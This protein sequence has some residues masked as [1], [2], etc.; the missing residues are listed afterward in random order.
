[1][2]FLYNHLFLRLEL[3]FHHHHNITKS[4]AKMLS[5]HL[6]SNSHIKNSGDLLR[7]INNINIEN[8]SLGSLNIKLLYTNIPVNKCIKY[9]ENL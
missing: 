3:P 8:K 5:L 2:E 6:G 7:K 9:L 1:M 4:L